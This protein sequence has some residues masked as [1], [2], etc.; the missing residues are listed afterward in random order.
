M[1]L[2]VQLTYLGSFVHFY[3]CSKY[4]GREHSRFPPLPPGGWSHR[5]A[6]GITR[7]GRIAAMEN[8]VSR[9]DGSSG[10]QRQIAHPFRVWVDSFIRTIMK[11]T[12]THT[13]TVILPACLGNKLTFR[14]STASQFGRCRVCLGWCETRDGKTV[15]QADPQVSVCCLSSDTH[16]HLHTNKHRDQL[17]IYN[18]MSHKNLTT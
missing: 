2:A 18:N 3:L 15:W 9:E 16:S 12:H 13:H 5:A 6:C 8:G 4:K 14:S 10:G 17:L 1:V 7:S 11:Q